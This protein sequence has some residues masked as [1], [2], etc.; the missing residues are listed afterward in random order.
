M[1]T[2]W[3]QIDE[4]IISRGELILELGFVEGYREEIQ[5]MNHG[6]TSPHTG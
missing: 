3:K 4:K 1:V 2:D 6:K 5:T